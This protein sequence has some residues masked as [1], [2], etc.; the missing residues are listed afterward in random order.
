MNWV[1]MV[2]SQVGDTAVYNNSSVNK[3][4]KSTHQCP[5][6]RPYTS[7]SNAIGGSL[8]FGLITFVTNSMCCG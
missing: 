4:L 5:H 7:Q 3:C 2:I 8:L 1:T 6:V